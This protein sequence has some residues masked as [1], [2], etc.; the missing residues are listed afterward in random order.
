[1]QNT[2]LILVPVGN[3]T[4]STRETWTTYVTL[5]DAT[6]RIQSY[7]STQNYIQ[8]PKKHPSLTLAGYQIHTTYQGNF[9]VS[10]IEE[11]HHC[12]SENVTSVT[13]LPTFSNGSDIFFCHILSLTVYL[14][15]IKYCRI[16][17]QCPYKFDLIYKSYLYSF[18]Q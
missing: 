4:S 11:S 8:V 6:F 12:L 1:M 14:R 15:K 7:N 13:R 2:W 10:E 16:T 5:K 9:I 3:K 18:K 17:H